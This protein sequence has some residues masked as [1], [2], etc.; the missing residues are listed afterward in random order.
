MFG[1]RIRSQIATLTTSPFAWVG[2]ALAVM[3]LGSI[4]TALSLPATADS[5]AAEGPKAS[6][7][8]QGAV[9]QGASLV[10]HDGSSAAECTSANAQ[11]QGTVVQGASQ[12]PDDEEASLSGFP[13]PVQW[14]IR[15]CYVE[16]ESRVD[17]CWRQYDKCLGDDPPEHR[18]QLCGI[19][20][21]NCLDMSALRLDNLH[22]DLYRPLGTGVSGFQTAAVLYPAL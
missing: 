10:P 3:V 1:S 20:L 5:P 8:R 17:D 12:G 11:H 13:Q 4:S 21:N 15:Q 22:L 7:Q 6:A 9:L 14:C 18:D 2:V 16:H 19:R